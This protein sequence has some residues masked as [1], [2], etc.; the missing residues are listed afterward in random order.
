MF[1]SDLQEGALQEVPHEAFPVYRVL[2][3]ST[4][5]PLAD[6]EKRNGQVVVLSR[7][8]EHY[9]SR[10]GQRGLITEAARVLKPGELYLPQISSGSPET[11][12]AFELGL[13]TIAGKEERFLTVDDYKN[14]LC[15]VAERSGGALFEVLGVG[16][17]EPQPRTTLE[18]ARRYMTPWFVRLNYGKFDRCEA[19]L[20]EAQASMAV[21]EREELRERVAKGQLDRDSALALLDY[22]NQRR[23]VYQP[24]KNIFQAA[25]SDSARGKTFSAGDGLTFESDGSPTITLTYPIPILRRT[26]HDPL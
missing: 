16:Y 17:A 19:V 18:L 15:E 13:K 14:L 2:S 20:M 1:V 6:G 23:R 24:F 10:E 3:D 21:G 5:L 9:L 26:H 12:R 8:V 22:G 4:R 25:V 11:L 7:A